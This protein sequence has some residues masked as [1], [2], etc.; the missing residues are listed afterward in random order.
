MHSYSEKTEIKNAF[1]GKEGIEGFTATSSG[2]RTHLLKKWR[3]PIVIVP[4][5]AS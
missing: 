5:L 2:T 3:A 4:S 1:F